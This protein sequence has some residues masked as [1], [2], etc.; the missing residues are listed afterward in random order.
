M[1]FSVLTR[2]T[3][4]PGDFKLDGSGLGLRTASMLAQQWGGKLEAPLLPEALF[5]VDFPE[6][7]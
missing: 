2:N 1:R 6:P 7:K 5:V 4:L 3:A